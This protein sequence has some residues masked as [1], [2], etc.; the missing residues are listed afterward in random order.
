MML[1]PWAEGPFELIVHG[2]MHLRS[3]QEFD[4]RMALISF[5]NSIEVSI[6]TYLG[7]HPIQ[8]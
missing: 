3:G 8:R 7:L 5:D 2:E 6:H 4:R 1:P